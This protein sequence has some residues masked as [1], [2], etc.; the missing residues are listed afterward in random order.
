MLLCCCVDEL[1]CCCVDVLL[2]CYI[3][4]FHTIEFQ[5]RHTRLCISL[6]V[7]VLLDLNLSLFINYV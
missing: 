6:H 7:S 5:D 1:L 3:V 4:F 2:C